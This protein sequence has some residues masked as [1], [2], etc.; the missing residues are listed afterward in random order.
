MR[1][2]RE[3]IRETKR[4]KFGLGR[5][6]DVLPNAQRTI[7]RPLD[8]NDSEALASKRNGSCKSGG[9]AADHGDIDLGGTLFQIPQCTV[10]K[11]ITTPVGWVSC[12][13]SEPSNLIGLTRPVGTFGSGQPAS[14]QAFKVLR[15]VRPSF[16]GMPLSNA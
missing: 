9:S 4:G 11:P 14:S 15:A 3:H 10:P 16:P 1:S 7:V 12:S 2:G 8:D 13:L 6:G 5:W